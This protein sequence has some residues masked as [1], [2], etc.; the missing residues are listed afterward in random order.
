MYEPP[1][2]FIARDEV[3][4]FG[5]SLIVSTINRQ[6]S[7]AIANGAW[8]SETICFDENGHVIA[9]DAGSTNSRKWHDDMVERIKRT[10]YPEKQEEE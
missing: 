1:K 9:M 6:S 7:S 5:R 2:I 4:A 8:Y 10:G 3:N